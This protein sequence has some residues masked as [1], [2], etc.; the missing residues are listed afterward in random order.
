MYSQV[1]RHLY[2]LENTWTHP[3]IYDEVYRGISSS[4]AF[5]YNDPWRDFGNTAF[6]DHH[7]HYGYWITASAILK[8]LDPS[9]SR[10][11]ELNRMVNLMVRDAANPSTLDK[12]FP[13]FRN[14]D[15]FVGHSYSH[16]VSPFADGKDQESTSEEIN[17]HYG[18]MLWGKASGNTNLEQLGKL[19]LKVNSR[20]INYYFLMTNDNKVH[21]KELLPNKVTGIF[22]DS[23]VDYA[24]WFGPNRE[25]IHGIQMIPV[26]PIQELY[27]KREFVRQ[28]WEQVLSK[29]DIFANPQAQSPWQSLLFA[30]VA[31][32]NQ[33][34]ALNKLT[35]V[36]MDD[37]LSRSW[38]LYYAATRPP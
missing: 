17:F 23:K 30:N 26:S 7:Y 14:F 11:N 6:N 18:L 32:V 16:A 34:L 1:A 24:T 22:F 21:P 36:P 29:I 5:K 25:Y 20:A 27:R 13:R 3:L 9:W 4:E 8:Y 35:I 15:W 28:E 33:E 37:G 2:Y 12:W 10:M 31:S 19:M 38:A